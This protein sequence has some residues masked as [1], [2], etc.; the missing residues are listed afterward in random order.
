MGDASPSRDQSKNDE[1][2][3]AIA[4]PYDPSFTQDEQ[5]TI[6]MFDR[7]SRKLGSMACSPRASNKGTARGFELS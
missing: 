6:Y 4:S 3:T 2:N 7:K 5:V 1:A